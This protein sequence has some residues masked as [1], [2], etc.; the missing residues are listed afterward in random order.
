[1]IPMI[2]ALIAGLVVL[3][4]GVMVEAQGLRPAA[5]PVLQCAPPDVERA[6][7]EDASS[8]LVPRF[9]I[10]L[11]ETV[12]A[13]EHG[14]WIALPTGGYVWRLTIHAP[15][16]Q[17]LLLLA[18]SL[19][20]D[21][22]THLLVSDRQGQVM[23]SYRHRPDARNG[24]YTIGPIAGD[25]LALEF[26]TPGE[27]IDLQ[28]DHIYYGFTSDFRALPDEG[29]VAEPESMS[30]ACLGFGCSL[31]CQVNAHCLQHPQIRRSMNSVVR[32]LLVFQEGASWC[33]GALINNERQ[34][35]TPYV[36]SAFHC[37]HGYTPWF[38]FWAY[39]F[40]YESQ[41]CTT[42]FQE[43][44]PFKVT[45]SEMRARWMNSDFL[46][47]EITDDLPTVPDIT[48]AGW[49]R[50]D[51]YTPAPTFF[52]HHPSAD[53]KKVSVDSQAVTIWQTQVT[54]NN[55]I[56][57]P[58]FHHYRVFFDL[59]TS[60]PGSS[61]G[62]LFDL[63]GRII[64]Q[65]NGGSANC[66]ANAL[67]F[68]RLQR[69]WSGGGTSDSRLRDWLDPDNKGV[70]DIGEMTV[71]GISDYRI[72]GTLLTPNGLPIP[73]ATVNLSGAAAFTTS[74]ND[75]G[76]YLF[77]TVPAGFSYVISANRNETF[78]F[79]VSVADVVLLN[80]FLLGGSLPTPYAHIAADVNASGSISIADLIELRSLLLGVIPQFS[81]V[82]SWI[83]LR[84]GFPFQ[85]TW[86]VPNLM[87]DI[88]G[89]DFI[90]VKSG[91]LNHSAV[92]K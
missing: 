1:M 38:H 41:D 37:Q 17:S 63:S 81:G 72:S 70:M 62:P 12:H 32:I 67:W 3:L 91:D 34:D 78:S 79:G 71:K 27:P 66:Q 16:A 77:D 23:E 50:Q 22:G 39:F 10:P 24:A 61:G 87:Q 28:I 33:S 25:R 46:L 47:L 52:L 36:L 19:P 21:P 43:P 54:W 7:R 11:R 45:G 92:P 9:A 31:P 86:Q 83:F 53:I 57:T 29:P 76:E 4:A 48:F 82:P 20:L 89:M 30:S 59:G 5:P 68:G 42:P 65:L 88:Q 35:G 56:V 75:Q 90:G 64:G 85:G 73:N 18:N 60:E 51:N 58:G 69:S 15:G 40:R 26:F 84:T 2:R 8:G 44:I 13:L 6:Q 49:T 80:Q 55:Q 14:E 74:T